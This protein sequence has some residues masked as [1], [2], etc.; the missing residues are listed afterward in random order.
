MTAKCIKRGTCGKKSEFATYSTKIESFKLLEH[1]RVVQLLPHSRVVIRFANSL[2]VLRSILNLAYS[3]IFRTLYNQLPEVSMASI[4]SVHGL[5]G[6]SK[7]LRDVTQ[8]TLITG[9]YAV[10][11]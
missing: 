11:S 9:L 4:P 6:K 5:T 8:A 1:S 3:H 7:S 10:P 2:Q